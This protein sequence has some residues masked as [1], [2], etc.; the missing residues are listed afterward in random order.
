MAHSQMQLN[1][2]TVSSHHKNNIMQIFS[3]SD[4]EVY[5]HLGWDAMFGG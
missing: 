2:D 5:C 1:R 3:G 4:Y